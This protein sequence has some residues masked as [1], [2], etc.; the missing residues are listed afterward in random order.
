MRGAQVVKQRGTAKRQTENS[1][2]FRASGTKAPHLND[3]RRPD[4]RRRIQT[5]SSRF[6]RLVPSIVKHGASMYVCHS[7]SCRREFQ[8]G[9][10]SAGFEVR[11]ESGSSDGEACRVDRACVTQ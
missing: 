10:E 4:V 1:A 6:V 3:P 11:C 7:S 5:V 8:N 9:L 2:S